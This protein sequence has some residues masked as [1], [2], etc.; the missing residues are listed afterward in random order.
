MVL[1]GAARLAIA[2]QG[3]Y[4][5]EIEF[6]RVEGPAGPREIVLVFFVGG[7]G[8]REKE[9]GRAHVPPTSSGGHAFAVEAYCECQPDGGPCRL[10]DDYVV[11]SRI[12]EVVLREPAFV[13]QR[14]ETVTVCLSRSPSGN[15]S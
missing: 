2:K 10:I 9:P 8:D 12:A 13:V 6:S 4:L 14:L 7:V 11:L 5:G 3:I 15:S 1:S